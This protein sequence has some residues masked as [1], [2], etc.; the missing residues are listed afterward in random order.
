VE[1][2]AEPAFSGF[3]A[4]L[5][6]FW[7][8][9]AQVIYRSRRIEFV[10]V[11]DY[12]DRLR[13]MELALNLVW[14]VIASASYVFLFRRLAIRGARTA[15]GPSQAQCVIALTCVLAILFPVISLTDDLH[16]MQATAEEA[17][18]SGT[19]IKRCVTSCSSTPAQS[20]HHVILISSPMVTNARWAATGV[21]PAQPV[22]R[23]TPGLH[24]SALG[25]S[26]PEFAGG[27]ISQQFSKH[28]FAGQTRQR[29]LLL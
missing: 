11:S 15:R 7:Y 24:L 2:D 25:R 27:E 16:E 10:C 18:V 28:A 12:S 3:H 26:P 21:V 19:A 13:I 29:L 20:L 22:R 14:A 17:S 23:S 9:L 6:F 1:K 8:A 5:R 4:L